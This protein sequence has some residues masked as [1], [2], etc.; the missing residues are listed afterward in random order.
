M[1]K[2][3]KVQN[4]VKTYQVS[5][6]MFIYPK[7]NNIWSWFGTSITIQSN[8]F[9]KNFVSVALMY[10]SVNRFW[11]CLRTEITKLANEKEGSDSLFSCNPA[12]E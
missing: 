9:W 7:F 8:W 2:L 6:N 1:S 12:I 10:K 5:F 3:L 11:N 4:F